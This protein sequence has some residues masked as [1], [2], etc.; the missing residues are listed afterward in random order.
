MI[1]QMQA[2]LIDVH[3]SEYHWSQDKPTRCGRW[4]VICSLPR[5]DA[6]GE[7]CLDSRSAWSDVSTGASGMPTVGATSTGTTQ[8]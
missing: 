6:A 4:L 1:N 2:Q 3:A 7:V 8:E 5:G